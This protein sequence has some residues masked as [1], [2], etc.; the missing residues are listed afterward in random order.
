MRPALKAAL[1]RIRAVLL[2]AV[3]GGPVSWGGHA[4]AAL[5]LEATLP[6]AAEQQSWATA[7]ARQT[8][9]AYQRYLE[10]FPT[11]L[12]AEEAFRRLI[13]SAMAQRPVTR[14][15]DVEPPLRPGGPTQRRPIAAAA[16]GLY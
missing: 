6:S 7:Q 9:E 13:E 1:D 8:P 5:G 12:Y 15:V 16:L 11:G 3:A 10:L 4:Q 14:M 2:A